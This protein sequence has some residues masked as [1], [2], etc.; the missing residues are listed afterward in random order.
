MASSA[1]RAPPSAPPSSSTFVRLCRIAAVQPPTAEPPPRASSSLKRRRPEEAPEGHAG[2]AAEAS[3]NTQEALLLQLGMLTARLGANLEVAARLFPDMAP[4]DGLLG[5]SLL[6]GCTLY[7]YRGGSGSG[8]G[9]AEVVVGIDRIQARPVPLGRLMLSRMGPD[10]VLCLRPFESP[11]WTYE[12]RRQIFGA[13]SPGAEPVVVRLQTDDPS[14]EAE[15]TGGTLRSLLLPDEDGRPLID[16]RHELW[17]GW[18]EQRGW[19]GHADAAAEVTPRVT[20]AL[21]RLDC[22]VRFMRAFMCGDSI[23]DGVSSEPSSSSSSSSSTNQG[24][25]GG[26]LRL[27]PSAHLGARRHAKLQAVSV[28]CQRF[29]AAASSQAACPFMLPMQ[30]CMNPASWLGLPWSLRVAEPCCRVTLQTADEARAA[31]DVLLAFRPECWPCHVCAGEAA[32]SSSDGAVRIT[33]GTLLR[34][35]ETTAGLRANAE[36]DCSVWGRYPTSV[37]WLSEM[38]IRPHSRAPHPAAPRSFCIFGCCGNE[39]SAAPPRPGLASFLLIHGSFDPEQPARAEHFLRHVLCP[40][41]VAAVT[42]ARAASLLRRRALAL[43]AYLGW[44]CDQMTAPSRPG[45]MPRGPLYPRRLD[46]DSPV[47]TFVDMDGLLGYAC[48]GLGRAL[49]PPPTDPDFCLQCHG[50]RPCLCTLEGP[51][52]E[53]CEA[54]QRTCPS[55]VTSPESLRW[56]VAAADAFREELGMAPLSPERVLPLAVAARGVWRA[57]ERACVP[58]CPGC[59]ARYELVSG[60]T[61]VHCDACGTRHCHA[62]ARRF[63]VHVSPRSPAAMQAALADAGLTAG[64]AADLFALSPDRE[65]YL[66][67]GETEQEAAAT[68]FMHG[69]DPMVHAVPC[70]LS[71]SSSCCPLYLEERLEQNEEHA[72]DDWPDDQSPDRPPLVLQSLRMLHGDGAR[73]CPAGIREA[74]GGSLA[75]SS[76]LQAAPGSSSPLDRS[77]IDVLGEMACAASGAPPKDRRIV[78]TGVILR[79]TAALHRTLVRATQAPGQDDA[80]AILFPLLL[81][82][83]RRELLGCGTG[84]SVLAATSAPPLTALR[85]LAWLLLPVRRMPLHQHLCVTMAHFAA[86]YPAEKVDYAVPCPTKAITLPVPADKPLLFVAYDIGLMLRAPADDQEMSEQGERDETLSEQGERDAEI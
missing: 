26:S 13:R 34:H 74:L 42:P 55:A 6:D 20:F 39:G 58:R 43:C 41:V 29:I 61:H 77:A 80:G 59:D 35:V 84:G 85:F 71:M 11:A 7:G 54:P 10:A 19:S 49:P 3:R 33:L 68:E 47:L 53:L 57:L 32:R 72:L 17:V 15:I 75:P 16:P 22:A 9:A 60:C 63:P 2:G 56:W 24:S 30:P 38:F 48:P 65:F 5:V 64:Q 81:F 69:E 23:L 21:R 37:P 28:F 52:A 66:R 76:W 40:A 50:S 79:A 62:C 8:G 70:H 18:S 45:G 36:L 82:A 1:D 78:G 83:G 14:A 31:G 73:L 46:L 12:A 67:S 44:C 25:G 86:T 51:R 4:D 27:H